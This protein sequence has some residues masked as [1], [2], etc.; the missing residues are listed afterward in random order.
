MPLCFASSL[1]PGYL[2]ASSW[3]LTIIA[4][5]ILAPF[6]AQT[7]AEKASSKFR[8]VDLFCFAI[9]ILGVVLVESS[10]FAKTNLVTI[11]IGLAAVLV[12]AFA[13][14]L[15]N[16]Q[17]MRLN[18]ATAN[19]GTGERIL[20]MILA[21]LPTWLVCSVVA[22]LR[23]GAPSSQQLISSLLVAIFSGVL[24]TFLF[25][26]ATHLVQTNLRKL[27][28]VEA[29]QSLEV[30]FTLLLS[31][32]VLHTGFPGWLALLGVL[33]IVAGISLKALRN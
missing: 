23:S 16:R 14:P 4:G 26:Q 22:G 25:F 30:L 28:T 20:A 3:Q 19:L 12:A 18:L 9:I 6:L 27:A 13:Y 11:V 29:S 24:A 5:S 33:L 8:R 7:P 17:V 2:V 15:G 1:A 32:V 31:I 21:S 10:H